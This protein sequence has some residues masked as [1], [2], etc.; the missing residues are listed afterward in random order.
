[1][2]K[3]ATACGEDELGRPALYL[4]GGEQ[5]L[6]EF[7]SSR[8]T[9]YLHARYR[10]AEDRWEALPDT[11][12]DTGAN[13]DMDQ[14]AVWL[15]GI[16]YVTSAYSDKKA[17]RRFDAATMAW[18]SNAADVPV[19]V[20]GASVVAVGAHLY[21]YG[22]RGRDDGEPGC[23]GWCNYNRLYRYDPASNSW[24]RMAD[25]PG[26]ENSG[27]GKNGRGIAADPDVPLAEAKIYLHKA[28]QDAVYAYSVASN[29]WETLA[30]GM[31]DAG[32]NSVKRGGGGSD[33]VALHGRL[34]YVSGSRWNHATGSWEEWTN[35][36]DVR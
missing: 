27:P 25:P 19:S 9:G 32:G 26:G 23:S 35:I 21:L 20:W 16:V 5:K 30:V 28:T 34:Y 22:G 6:T 36:V 12:G 7:S 15:N 4:V 3:A 13:V 1:M 33:L 31:A 29:T 24:A 10:I 11:P 17:V 14:T 2:T 18:L 8:F